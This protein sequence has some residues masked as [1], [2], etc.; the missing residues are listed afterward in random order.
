VEHVP[1]HFNPA[2]SVET[3]ILGGRAGQV[4]GGD[5]VWGD[6]NE[7]SRHQITDEG[8]VVLLDGSCA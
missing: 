2:V 8:V 1:L 7:R 5:A 3:V 4:V 6:W